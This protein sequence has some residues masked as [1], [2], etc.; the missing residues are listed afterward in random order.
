VDNRLVLLLV[1]YFVAELVSTPSLDAPSGAG[2][3]KANSAVSQSQKKE[4]AAPAARRFA[5]TSARSCRAAPTS[6]F[7]NPARDGVCRKNRR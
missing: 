6:S 3:G 2:A 1:A 4:A 5:S 7:S